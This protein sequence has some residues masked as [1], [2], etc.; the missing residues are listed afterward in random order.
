MQRVEIVV[1]RSK[2]RIRL[3]DFLFE[4]FPGLGRMYLRRVVKDEQCE[5]NGRLENVGYRQL[6]NL[7]R[8]RGW[9][10]FIRKSE[11]RGEMTRKGFQA[12]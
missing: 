1:E 4:Q 12:S 11:A 8:I 9:W 5:V 6:N 7:W 2:S 10:Q 3:E